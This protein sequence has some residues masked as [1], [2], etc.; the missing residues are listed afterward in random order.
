MKNKANIGIILLLLVMLSCTASALSLDVLDKN[1]NANQI[2]QPGSSVIFKA[3]ADNSTDN[4]MLIIIKQEIPIE[5]ISMKL[6]SDSPRQ[7]AYEYIVPQDFDGDYYA[8][9]ISKGQ[10]AD[11]EFFVGSELNGEIM[12][13]QDIP[14]AKGMHVLQDVGV[15]VKFVLEKM[16]WIKTSF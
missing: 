15:L 6:L 2:F 3:D 14:K 1:M 8:K 5:T 12:A 11:A 9:V 7:F 16:L 13:R 4:L 10:T